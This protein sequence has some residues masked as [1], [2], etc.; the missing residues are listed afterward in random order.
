MT[1]RTKSARVAPVLPHYIT[2]ECSPEGIIAVTSCMSKEDLDDFRAF[3]PPGS[4]VAT[5][6]VNLPGTKRE[7][8]DTRSEEIVALFGLITLPGQRGAMPWL[9][10]REDHKIAAPV[11]FV[12]FCRELLQG[13]L[14]NGHEFLIAPKRKEDSEGIKFVTTLGFEQVP[15]EHIPAGQLEGYSLFILLPNQAEVA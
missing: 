2:R 12:Q 14:A 8:I 6:F 5:H 13:I 10:K 15:A 1:T 7:V 9:V 3:A 4:R 11:Q